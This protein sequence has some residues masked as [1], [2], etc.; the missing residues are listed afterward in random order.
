M[1]IA[2]WNSG[3]FKY[4][5]EV[6]VQWDNTAAICGLHKAHVSGEKSRKMLS[7]NLVHQ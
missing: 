3:F 6:A 5:R 2:S 1:L 4:K 7:R